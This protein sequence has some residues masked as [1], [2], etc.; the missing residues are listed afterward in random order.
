MEINKK[1]CNGNSSTGWFDYGRDFLF[2]SSHALSSGIVRREEKAPLLQ[3]LLVNICEFCQFTHDPAKMSVPMS[4][5]RP[6]V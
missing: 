6:M 4:M 2:L 5:P 3:S 1:M